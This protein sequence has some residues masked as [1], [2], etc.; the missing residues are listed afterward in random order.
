MKMI[1]RSVIFAVLLVPL[2]V[3][4]KDSV[5][6]AFVVKD[7]STQFKY[8]YAYR[9]AQ[10]MDPS[11]S[12]LYVLL[13]DIAVPSDA[14]PAKEEA[15]SKIA[16]LVRENKIHALELRFNTGGT[17]KLNDAEQGAVYHNAIA[18]ARNGVSG[19]LIYRQVSDDGKVLRGEVKMDK[20]MA[21]MLGWT[22]DAKFEVA[23]PPK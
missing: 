18:P 8:V 23:L 6:G 12:D 15:L 9:K 5:S 21:G 7:K 2:V 11:K 14:L 19:P 10:R 22:A 13:S 3:F 17:D 20:D 4:G 16:Q 1:L